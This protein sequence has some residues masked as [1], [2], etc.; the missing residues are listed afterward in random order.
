MK[1]RSMLLG[2]A[3]AVASCA[4]P[5]WPRP[6][7]VDNDRSIVFPSFFEDPAVRVGAG[8]EPYELDGVVLRAIMIATVDFLRPGTKEQPCWG[9]PEAHRY[10]VIRQENVIFVRI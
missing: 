6:V 1:T 2:L 5:T 3:V 8:V 9:S 4:R 7:P 10:R